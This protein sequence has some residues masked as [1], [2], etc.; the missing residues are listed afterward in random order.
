MEQLLA[1]YLLILW[2]AGSFQSLVHLLRAVV[3]TG[4]LLGTL[5][6]GSFFYQEKTRLG[7]LAFIAPFAAGYL[8][9]LALEAV[10]GRSSGPSSSA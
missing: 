1:F 3:V 5:L 8:L 10:R 7:V 4:M 9:T 6:A 2:M